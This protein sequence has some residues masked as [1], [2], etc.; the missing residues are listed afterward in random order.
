MRVEFVIDYGNMLVHILDTNQD[1]T[2]SLTNGI[3]HFFGEIMQD[4]EAQRFDDF[5][6]I[7]YHTDGV[8]T[9]FWNPCFKPVKEELLYPPFR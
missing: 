8:V 6:W 4:I 9:E 7:C 2:T 5:K 3:H 1:D